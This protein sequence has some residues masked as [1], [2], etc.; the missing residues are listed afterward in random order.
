MGP[1]RQ[2]D[3][4]ATLILI[5]E[6]TPIKITVAADGP[7]VELLTEAPTESGPVLRTT[8]EVA[9]ALAANVITADGAITFDVDYTGG[10]EMLHTVLG[11][12]RQTPGSQNNTN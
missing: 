7:H 10:A 2:S 6:N 4:P 1:G 11:G 8:A 12:V 9:L 3:I 5:V